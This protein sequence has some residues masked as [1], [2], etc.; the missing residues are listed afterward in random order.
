[1][2]V[3]STLLIT[4]VTLT[5]SVLADIAPG[6]AKNQSGDW[7]SVSV[8]QTGL[9]VRGSKD[10]ISYNE[11]TSILWGKTV[12]GQCPYL[13]DNKADYRVYVSPTS[14]KREL[15]VVL[16]WED[17]RGGKAAW[18]VDGKNRSVLAKNIVPERWGIAFWVSWSPNED[19]ALFHAVGEVTMGDMVFVNLASGQSRELH[20]R[21]FTRKGAD[22]M[23]DFNRDAL[24]WADPKSFRLN[25]EIHCDPYSLGDDACDQEKIL[26]SHPARINLSPFSISYG[27]VAQ[28]RNPRARQ[29]ASARSQ[30]T[31]RGIRSVDFR[32]FTYDSIAGE[33]VTL[34]KGQNLVKGEYSAGSYGSELGTVKYLDFDGDGAEEALVVVFY[35]QEAAGVYAE[36]HYYVFAYRNG[37][38]QQIFHESRY[39]GRGIRVSG[40]SLIITAPFWKDTDGHCCPSLTEIS[41]Y[42]W[43]GNGFVRTSRKFTPWK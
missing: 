39:K 6:K 8:G 40:K 33:Q 2:N 23:Q 30:Q 24:T 35:S 16:C 5:L 43:R 22:E 14:P 13:V 36:E 1:M 28:A 31:G 15:F 26:R 19:F 21:D 20:F 37:A 12:I 10:N 9:L 18:I 29:R 4:L 17:H 34:R 25:I 41:T 7:D 38:A 11:D 42:R 27:N 32:N 3:K